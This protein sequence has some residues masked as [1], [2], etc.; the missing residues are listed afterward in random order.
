M[1]L[2]GPYF[3]QGPSAF[4]GT[5]TLFDFQGTGI[6]FSY[7][8]GLQ[9]RATERTTLGFNYQ[10]ETRFRLDGTTRVTIPTLGFSR[11]DSELAIAWPQSFTVG[12]KH[13]FDCCARVGLDVQLFD[14][15]SSF[16]AFGITL[17][18][19][20]S[21]TYQAVVGQRLDE[22][23][24][25]NWRDTVSIR[26]GGEQEL[27]RRRVVRAGYVYHRNPVPDAT[28]TPF[29]QATL[30]HAVSVGYGWWFLGNEWDAAYQYSFG[31]DRQVV[32][33]QFL[34]GDFDGSTVGTKAHW[35]SLSVI[36]RF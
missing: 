29:L 23:F 15:S 14:W 8:G 18:D 6:G 35:V 26:L 24:P 17:T 34:G 25:L 11:F 13:E 2:E 32:N 33:S 36:R 10:G 28:L 1:E 4:A 31:R 19:P 3:L 5:P 20:D 16:D 12:V 22:T 30:E 9:Y 21:P 27:G 7:A